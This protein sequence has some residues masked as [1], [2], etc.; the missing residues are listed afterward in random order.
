[1]IYGK[2]FYKGEFIDAGIEVEEGR[3]KRIGKLVRGKEVKGVILPAGIDVHVHFRDFEEKEKE[4]IETGS[5][6]ALHGGICLVVDQPNTK[7]VVENEEQYFRRMERAESRIYVDYALNLAL[8]NRN[9][10]Q[11]SKIVEKIQKKYFLPAIGEVFIYSN[12]KELQIS[13]EILKKLNVNFMITVHAED[14][15]FVEDGSPNF[16]YRKKEAEIVAVEEC[17]KIGK[18]HFCHL[19]TKEAVEKVK[20]G[21]FEV[22]PHHILLSIDDHHRLGEFVNVN[23]PLR[24]KIDSEW[25][26]NNFQRIPILASDHAPHTVENK[27]TGLPGFPGVETTF[28]IFV[29]LAKKGVVSFGDLVEKISINP[30]RIFRFE[31]YGAIEIGKLANFAVFDL[32]EIKEI[33]AEKLHS[34]CGWTPYEGF[35]A[36]FPK[37]VYLRGEEVLCNEE[38]A[39]RCIVKFINK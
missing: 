10:N 18:F 31:D 22:A 11:I 29:Y 12:D 2:I 6:A 20:R 33:R 27:K 28:P 39:G 13:Y 16:L 21:S 3:I 36:I 25:L 17:E 26:L 8:T 35:K 4:T 9:F 24:H 32:K 34:L 30:A 19:S 23:P 38:R 14:P 1:M 5:L 15:R 7:P 37:E